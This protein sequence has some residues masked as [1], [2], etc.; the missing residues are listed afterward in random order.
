MLNVNN[1]IGLNFVVITVFQTHIDKIISFL[2]FNLENSC[3]LEQEH[4]GKPG[5]E[6]F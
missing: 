4:L 3:K 2:L 5:L 6:S 1:L